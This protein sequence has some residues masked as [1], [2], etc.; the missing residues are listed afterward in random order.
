MPLSQKTRFAAFKLR[1]TSNG[2]E[3]IYRFDTL[4]QL[5]KKLA[6][7]CIHD[8]TTARKS[9]KD[10]AFLYD[11]DFQDRFPRIVENF[12]GTVLG[13]QVMTDAQFENLNWSFVIGFGIQYEAFAQNG[14][15]LK[16]APLLSAGQE[17]LTAIKAERIRRRYRN[18]PGYCGYG[19]VPGTRKFRGG[20][21]YGR[22]YLRRIR[23]TAEIRMNSLTIKEDGEVSARPARCDHNLPTYWDDQPR[24]YQN[25][26]KSQG[27][28]SKSWDR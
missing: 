11:I 6:S 2:S 8:Q 13:W 4:P 21:S 16:M 15:P 12:D 1:I 7:R 17:E 19:P 18:E 25:G 9:Y 3:E 26:W 22:L 23:T 14:M 5:A 27:K 28:R 24:S 10:V 20:R